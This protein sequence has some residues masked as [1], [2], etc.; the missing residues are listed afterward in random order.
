MKKLEIE[1]MFIFLVENDYIQPGF[2]IDTLI[3]QD[4]FGETDTESM[5][6]IGPMILLEQKILKETGYFC[7]SLDKCIYVCTEDEKATIAKRM[8]EKATRITHDAYHGLART[9]LNKISSQSLREEHQHQLNVL[10]MLNKRTRLI[11]EEL[12]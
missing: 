2:I 12:T 3:L 5:D 4:L 6:Y 1:N 11:L 10:L 7:K 9:D 8:Q